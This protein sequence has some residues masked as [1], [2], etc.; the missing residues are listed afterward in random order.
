MLCGTGLFQHSNTSEVHSH[1]LSAQTVMYTGI[2]ELKDVL[3]AVHFRQGLTCTLGLTN[4]LIG[5]GQPRAK[6]TV[7][8][9]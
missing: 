5:A 6:T 8:K 3:N 1:V 2:I 7:F 9:T 4:N